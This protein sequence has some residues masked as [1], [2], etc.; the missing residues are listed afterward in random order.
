MRQPLH[1]SGLS[2]R[3]LEEGFHDVVHTHNDL[4]QV[5]LVEA[6]RAV[7]SRGDVHRLFT[8]LQRLEQ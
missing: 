5:W 6:G 7:R 4:V 2:V 3:I 1:G 8:D